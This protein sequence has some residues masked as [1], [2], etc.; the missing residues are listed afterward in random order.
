MCQ[1]QKFIVNFKNIYLFF[2]LVI[3]C[4]K[5]GENGEYKHGVVSLLHSLWVWYWQWHGPF[6]LWV[7]I[8]DVS[9]LKSVAVNFEE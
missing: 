4:L 1:Y 6:V 5:V 9:Q 8:F 3:Q 7:Q 2:L